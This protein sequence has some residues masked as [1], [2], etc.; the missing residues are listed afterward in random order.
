MTKDQSSRRRQIPVTEHETRKNQERARI[1]KAL[2]HPS[3]I[4]IVDT[5]QKGP[6]CVQDLTG[7]IGA[8]TSTGS[9]HLS[10]LKNAG[11]V[12]DTKEGTTVY[13]AL[14]CG[15]I[16]QFLNGTEVIM[17]NNLERNA[18]ALAGSGTPE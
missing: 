12:Y 14:T 8:D 11:I 9:K 13:Y 17:R 16:Q 15:C 5:L 7:A 18:A 6:Q 2:A 4:F 3:R 10:V 1:L